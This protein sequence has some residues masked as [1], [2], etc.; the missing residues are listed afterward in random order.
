MT[1]RRARLR[2]PPDVQGCRWRLL[3]QT[4][5]M[6]PMGWAQ[7]A[8][9][10]AAW[11]PQRDPSSMSTHWNWALIGHRHRLVAAVVDSSGTTIALFSSRSGLV[12]LGARQFLRI[13]RLEVAPPRR[14]LRFGS[15]AVALIAA[16][17]K[18][19]GA[20]GLVMATDPASDDLRSFYSSLGGVC[21]EVA[22]WQ[23]EPG[24]V[25]WQ[26][27]GEAFAKLTEVADAQRIE[28]AQGH[29]V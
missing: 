28:G 5:T 12:Q 1:H 16:V 6:A 15:V 9:I 27:S 22:G 13:D 21:G 4:V 11:S 10:D 3:D 25:P 20:D 19:M 8:A 29:D 14:R 24:L 18:S 23:C 26:W 17:A 7:L 2:L